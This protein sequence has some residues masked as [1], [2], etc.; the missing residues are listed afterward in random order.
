MTSEPA[1]NTPTV[2]PAKVTI[3]EPTRIGKLKLAFLYVLIGG[4][5]ASALV[6]IIALLI[7]SFSSE[8]QK[9]LLTIFVFFSHSLFILA[10]LWADKNNEV[11]RNIL[12]TTIFTLAL[13]NMITS[14]LSTWEIISTQM[15]WR[16]VGLYVLIIGAV[17]VISGIWK[18]RINHPATKML[19]QITLGAITAIVIALIPWVLQLWTP[20]DPLYFRVIAALSIFASTSFLIAIILRSIALARHSQLNATKPV[21]KPIPSGLLAIYISVGTIVAMV[22]CAGFAGFLVSAVESSQANIHHS[23]SNRY[24]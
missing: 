4:L 20:L 12:P 9:S 2:H 16:F 19:L 15:S 14:T 17:F 6:A 11:G 1:Q 21:A 8:I 5:A 10:L 3:P 23:T 13:A 18:L 24:Y 7:G 22:W